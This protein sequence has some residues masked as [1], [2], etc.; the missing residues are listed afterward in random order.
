[1]YAFFVVADLGF[2]HCADG[3]DLPDDLFQTD[4]GQPGGSGELQT[5]VLPPGNDTSLQALL[6]RSTP[7]PQHSLANAISS[8][9]GH[10]AASMG[11]MASAGLNVHAVKSP[12][13]A[14]LSSPSHTVTMN[15][16]STASTSHMGGAGDSLHG[17]N[18]SM[19]TSVG[20]NPMM[21]SMNMKPMGPNG[22]QMMGM[23]PMGMQQHPAQMMNGPSFPPGMGPMR[24][25]APTTMGS[26]AMSL[27]NNMMGNNQ[28]GQMA[29]QQN[30]GQLMNVTQNQTQMAKV[31]V[32]Y[33]C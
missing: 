22:G 16:V 18:F 28:M 4:F 7:T 9:A 3:L 15:K 19:G 5:P 10:S 32:N 31:S 6:A 17:M 14:S 21:N 25:M 29:G 12:L 13:S 27:Q 23:Q 24:S 2:N 26:P 1:V 11:A 33:Y 30:L 20:N 8:M